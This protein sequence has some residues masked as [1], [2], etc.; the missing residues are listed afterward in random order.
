MRIVLSALSGLLFALSFPDASLTPLVFVALAPVI[1]SVTF[2]RSMREALLQ[3]QLFGTMVWLINVPW[4][5]DVMSI[6]G[7]LAFPV[8]VVIYILMAIFV[9]LNAA[10]FALLLRSLRLANSSRGWV[11][12]PFTWAAAE[13]IRAHYL[14]AFAWN[15]T[16]ETLI[17]FRTLV[18]ISSWTGPYVLGF[19]AAIPSAFFAWLLARHATNRLRV[20]S[21]AVVVVLYLIWFVC[22]SVLL[23]REEKLISREAKTVAALLQ[24]NVSQEEKWDPARETLIF[25]RMMRMSAE[26]VLSGAKV[27]IWPESTV[28]LPF[29]ETEFFRQAVENLSTVAGVDIILGSVAFD[30]SDKTK[31]WNTAFLVSA[32][33]AK[34][35]YDKIRLVPF[36]EFVPFRKALFFAEKLVRAVGEFQFGTNDRPMRGRFAYGPAICYEVVFPEIPA[37]QVRHGAN[38]LVTI[39]NDAWFDRT[40]APRQHL[41]AARL[42]AVETNRYLLRAATTGISAHVDPTGR[43]VEQLPL[44]EKGIIRAEFAPR[45]TLTPYVRFGDWFGYLTMLVVAVAALIQRKVS[46]HV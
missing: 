4:V 40:S 21:G 15:L 25:D 28:P 41:D 9:G 38:V 30:P 35:R 11:F 24:P 13:W 26:G 37:T 7:G 10:V 6:H 19:L 5:I 42:R 20:I 36:G 29:L 23:S 44:F 46:A 2:S 14:S 32:G 18:Q 33:E 16:A 27:V 3:G 17:D 31:L 8:G 1:L 45:Q 39:T 43:I 34:G 22:G 12:V